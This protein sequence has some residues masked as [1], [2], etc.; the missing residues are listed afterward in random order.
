MEKNVGIDGIILQNN[1]QAMDFLHENM[2]DSALKLLL[3]SVKL[4][5]ENSI[6]KSSGL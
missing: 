5:S 2:L 4:L 3:S 6:P 1:K